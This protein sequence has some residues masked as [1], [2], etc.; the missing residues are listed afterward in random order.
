M[1]TVENT[2]LRPEVDNV[3]GRLRSKIRTYVFLEGTAWVIVAL[4]AVFWVTLAM[5]WAYF[6]VSNLELPMWF[7]LLVDVA[8]IGFLAGCLMLWLVQRLLKN[9]RTKALALVLERRF[10]ELDDRLITA[11]EAVESSSDSETAFTRTLR[12]RTIEEVSE[13]TR[14]LEVGDVFAKRPLRNAVLFAVVFIASIGAFA[15]LNKQAMGYWL[16]AFV[17][18]KD[19]YWDRETL[20]V[21]H[22]ISPADEREKPFREIKDELVYK[23][24][25]GEDF[26]L[27][28][29]VPKS[30]KAD[31][32]PWIA[33]ETVE[34]DYELQNNR[35]GATVTMSKTGDRIFRYTVP[36]L[37]DG[38]TFTIR[39]NDY[40]NRR[41]FRVEIVDP[42]NIKQLILDCDYPDYTGLNPEFAA[43]PGETPSNVKTVDGSQ[44]SEPM[45]TSIVMNTTTNK[46]LTG[47]RVEGHNFRLTVKA[48]HENEAGDSVPAWAKFELLAQDG[49]PMLELPLE[50]GFADTVLKYGE[51]NFKLPVKLTSDAPLRLSPRTSP[52]GADRCQGML[53]NPF[54]QVTELSGWLNEPLE[55]LPLPSNTVLRIFLEDTD[56]VLSTEPS[57]LT[58]NGIVDQPPELDLECFGIG[59]YITPRAQIPVRGT[60]KDDYGVAKARFEFQLTNEAGELLSGPDWITR[61]F[62]NPPT[63]EPKT[64]TLKR[65][66]DN[67]DPED[68]E[69]FE[70][71]DLTKIV[72]QDATGPRGVRVGDVLHLTVYVEDGDNING[73][74]IVRQKPKPE[75]IFKVVSP[76]ELMLILSQKEL[77]L[78][79]RFQQIKT[80]VEGVEKDL[81]GAES[82]LADLNALRQNNPNASLDD[83]ESFKAVTATSARSI[84]QIGKN[85]GETGAVAASFRDIIAELDNNGMTSIDRSL[86]QDIIRLLDRIHNTDFPEVQDALNRLRD[87]HVRGSNASGELEES[88]QAVKNMLSNMKKAIEVMDLLVGFHALTKSLKETI[89]GTEEAKQKAAEEA[90]KQLEELNKLLD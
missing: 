7:R 32:K 49:V 18:L 36:N 86:H 40:V 71:F 69:E 28:V 83:E 87:V 1:A 4:G 90:I 11:V 59:E 10:P 82:Q 2:P 70:R 16:D 72:F 26:T 20:L 85:K 14:Q 48:A 76:D 6:K 15:T 35:G 61:D 79:T 89:K 38:M 56:D 68:D 45:E 74:H 81:V 9:M 27:A 73:P 37:I 3:L 58:I 63:T 17:G 62:D 60:I 22:V 75:Y 46:P 42:P 34:L 13:A 31:G 19:E 29:T 52:L 39:G 43:D 25:R 67:D 47:F 57:Q 24:P 53:L 84:Q 51:P 12:D 65:D 50:D 88:Q 23:H 66:M 64:Y 78:L 33:P 21:P 30:E 44:V 55:H 5:N 8:A 77:G 54:L 80:E 41:P